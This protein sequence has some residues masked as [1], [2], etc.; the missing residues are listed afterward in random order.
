MCLFV[1]LKVNYSNNVYAEDLH[2]SKALNSFHY[3]KDDQSSGFLWNRESGIVIKAAIYDVRLI[4]HFAD[5]DHSSDYRYMDENPNNSE[6][7]MKFQE[8]VEKF[9]RY[10]L[11]NQC[12]W[13]VIIAVCFIIRNPI[14]DSYSVTLEISRDRT[15]A[16]QM[17]TC[18]PGDPSSPKCPRDAKI[19]E[20]F[21]HRTVNEPCQKMVSERIRQNSKPSFSR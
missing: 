16:A 10:D 8:I 9:C 20:T 5:V 12:G 1:G 19:G 6:D 2:N 7:K 18:N 3:I 17:T 4:P 11:Y 13:K 21:L 15:T 14:P